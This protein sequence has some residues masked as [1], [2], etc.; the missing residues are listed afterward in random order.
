[1]KRVLV[2]GVLVG[3]GLLA[4]LNW[5]DGIACRTD[6]HCPDDMYCGGDG[7]CAQGSRP[8]DAGFINRVDAGR[9]DGG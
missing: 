8:N 6:H 7:G 9:R 4:C 3:A 1:M 2:L 5:T